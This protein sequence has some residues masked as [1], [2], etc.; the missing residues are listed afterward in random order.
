M[1]GELRPVEDMRKEHR[2]FSS[3]AQAAV[4]KTEQEAEGRWGGPRGSDP[5]FE[6]TFVCSLIP[7]FICYCASVAC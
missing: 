2:H 4:E 7:S 5:A 6:L 3:N 1:H